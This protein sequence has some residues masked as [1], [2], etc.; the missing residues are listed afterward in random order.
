MTQ[1]RRQGIFWLLLTLSFM[2]LIFLKSNEPYQQQDLKPTLA[3]WVSP[4][5]LDAWLPRIEFYYDQQLITWKQ[6]YSMAEFFIRKAGHVS[7][8]A[9][10]TALWMRTLTFTRL[11]RANRILASGGIS[12]LY[13]ASDE[14]HQTFIPG[15]TGHSIDVVVDSLGILM[16]LAIYS[17]RPLFKK[18]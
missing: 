10:L 16:V 17:V 8:F 2:L 12:L 11:E 7:E 3:E 9:I 13:A 5:L 6:P 18:P 14:W 15:R 1:T 4:Q